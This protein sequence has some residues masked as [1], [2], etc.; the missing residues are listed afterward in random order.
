MTETR[1]HLDLRCHVRRSL[2]SAEGSGGRGEEGEGL[3]EN[4]C[5]KGKQGETAHRFQGHQK[6]EEFPVM[7]CTRRKG[8][9]KPGEAAAL[10]KGS[11]L[12]TGLG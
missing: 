12:E 8:K 6:T 10:A 11:G 4:T 2:G 5:S 9:L 1:E 3:G 7:N